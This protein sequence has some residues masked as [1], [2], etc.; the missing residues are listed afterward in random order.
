[1]ATKKLKKIEKPI[2]KK[3]VKAKPIANTFK[4]NS[5]LEKKVTLNKKGKDEDKVNPDVKKIY[6]EKKAEHKNNDNKKKFEE[7]GNAEVIIE[8]PIVE[9]S[10]EEMKAA[11]GR[12][13]NYPYDF[14]EGKKYIKCFLR[15]FYALK[16]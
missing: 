9:L 6:N 7:G 1:M 14:I 2:Q 15:P 3:D 10:I 12:E 5:K 13:P 11:L 4:V 8:N 16:Y